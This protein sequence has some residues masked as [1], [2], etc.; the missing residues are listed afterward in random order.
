MA[1]TLKRPKR[2]KIN[3]QKKKKKRENKFIFI[4]KIIKRLLFYKYYIFFLIFFHHLSNPFVFFIVETCSTHCVF[5]YFITA[6]TLSS[7][8]IVLTKATSRDSAQQSTCMCNIHTF[9]GSL[10]QYT[11][12]RSE[13]MKGGL[14][15]FERKNKRE[16]AQ[17]R[18][19]TTWSHHDS[20][21]MFE[22]IWISGN[23]ASSCWRDK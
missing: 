3:K 23:E 17:E 16:T 13:K 15:Q 1:N 9:T 21:M 14:G 11:K 4:T 2:K 5:Y 6:R 10:F 20:R 7:I 19:R 22:R 18:N 8:C 12:D